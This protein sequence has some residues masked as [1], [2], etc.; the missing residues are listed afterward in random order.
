M[1]DSGSSPTNCVSPSPLS[2]FTK[3]FH[4]SQGVLRVSAGGRERTPHVFAGAEGRHPAK[5]T[6]PNSSGGLGDSQASCQLDRRPRPPRRESVRA[7]TASDRRQIKRCVALKPAI[8]P[9]TLPG[10]CRTSPATSA[11]SAHHCG[12]ECS[13]TAQPF[14]TSC[15]SATIMSRGDF[16]AAP[17]RLSMRMAKTTNLIC[18]MPAPLSPQAKGHQGRSQLPVHS[19]DRHTPSASSPR[20]HQRPAMTALSRERD[21]RM[22]TTGHTSPEESGYKWHFDCRKLCSRRWRHRPTFYPAD[23]SATV[24]VTRPLVP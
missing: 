4:K 14:G 18:C 15:M 6:T 24:R 2:Q 3:H 7:P 1:R 23:Y 5:W 17:P 19:L 11:T 13:G 16:S 9:L 12:P 22:P 21:M 20:P 10:V 8:S